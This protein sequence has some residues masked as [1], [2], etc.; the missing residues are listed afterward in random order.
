MSSFSFIS[1]HWTYTALT[2]KVAVYTKKT[3]ENTTVIIDQIVTLGK[4]CVDLLKQLKGML[5]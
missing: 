4:D 1:P 3:F 5:A 2:T